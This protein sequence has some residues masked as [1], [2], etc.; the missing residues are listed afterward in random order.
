MDSTKLEGKVVKAGVRLFGEHQ[1]I[2]Y[3]DQET[4]NAR[5]FVSKRFT[6]LQI[7]E[8][9]NRTSPYRRGMKNDFFSL[10]AQTTTLGLMTYRCSGILA[11]EQVSFPVLTLQGLT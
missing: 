8:Q 10:D 11:I 3:R 9:T 5:A 2:C 4:L 7:A 1:C 6:L